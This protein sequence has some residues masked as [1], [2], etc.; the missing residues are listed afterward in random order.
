MVILSQDRELILNFSTVED[1]WIDYPCNN[2]MEMFEIRAET[3]GN[4]VSIGFYNGLKRAK[5]VLKDILTI[6][7]S[8]NAYHSGFVLNDIYYMPED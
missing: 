3:Y 8:C 1:L 5:E 2:D 6:Y 7:K 4:I